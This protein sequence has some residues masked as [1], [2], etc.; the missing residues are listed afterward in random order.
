MGTICLWNF[1]DDRSEAEVG[2]ELLPEFQGKGLMSEALDSVIDFC[3]SRI[4]FEII[5]ADVHMDNQKSVGLLK[6][7]NFVRIPGEDSPPMHK[8][9][10]RRK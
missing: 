10:L 7:Y 8:Y 4:N 3:F 1:S 5:N 2:F 9:Q 6:R